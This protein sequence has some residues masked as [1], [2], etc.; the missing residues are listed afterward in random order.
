MGCG[1]FNFQATTC[2]QVDVG[3]DFTQVLSY[4]DTGGAVDI[5]GMT[6][7]LIVKDALA[8]SALLT[9]NH[10]GDDI[11]T[12]LYIADPS[13]GVIQVVIIDADTSGIAAGEYPYQMTKTLADGKISIFMQ[14]TMGFVDR[15]F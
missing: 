14:G 11:S 4:T 3:F 12:G 7:Q 9:L 8:G 6:F 2:T 1:L 5:T 15:G 10:V 13:T